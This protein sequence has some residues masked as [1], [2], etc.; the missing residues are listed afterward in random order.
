DSIMDTS[1]LETTPTSP[2]SFSH[3]EEQ[4]DWSGSQQTVVEKELSTY[5]SHLQEAPCSDI[6]RQAANAQPPSSMPIRHLGV[7]PLIRASR[8][9]LARPAW[10]SEES[11]SV[12]SDSYGSTFSLYRG[13]T[14]SIPISL[15]EDGFR[16]EPYGD[17]TPDLYQRKVRDT[18]KTE[19][20]QPTWR[21]SV[22]PPPSPAASAPSGT[23]QQGSRTTL[24]GPSGQPSTPLTP[25]K[26]ILT[27]AEY[28]DN[29]PEE[30][31]EKV[32]KPKSSALSQTSTQESRPQ[33]PLS[34]TSSKV[35]VLRPSPKLV[36]SG[37]KIFDKVKYYEERRKSF[38]Q[39]D[40]PFPVHSWLPFRK[41]RSFDQPD[42]N[43]RGGRGVT[44][45]TSTEDLR[46]I[47]S[48]YGGATQRRTMFKQKASSFDERSKFASRVHD[49][50]HKFSEELSR[51]KK[52]VSKQQMARSQEL[53]RLGVKGGPGPRPVMAFK[54]EPSSTLGTH[55]ITTQKPKL[56]VAP[57]SQAVGGEQ[58]QPTAVV[59]VRKGAEDWE[60]PV[61]TVSRKPLERSSVLTNKPAEMEETEA[62]DHK[63]KV[64]APV[65]SPSPRP[66][67]LPQILV[68][69]SKEIED[70]SMEDVEKGHV[71]VGERKGKMG[72]L[73]EGKVT[74]SKGKSK[75][76][77]PTSPETAESSDDSY[78]SAGEDPLEPPVFEIPIQDTV[79]TA[80]SEVLL[81]CI[82]TGNP[83]P[84]VCWK[85]DN[86]ILKSCPTHLIKAEGERHTLLI[87]R[88]SLSDAGVYCISA[89]NEEGMSSSSATLKVK[90]GE[91]GST[92]LRFSFPITSD[93]EYLSPLE[94][95]VEFG[96]ASY[97][98]VPTMKIQDAMDRNACEPRSPI[99]AHFKA[100]PT[101]EVS[102]CDQ[103]V[104]E[105][106]DVTLSVRVQGEPKPM[107]Y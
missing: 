79:V 75:R 74:R 9:N 34:E 85:K 63:T 57:M 32:K 83:L 37:S 96:V 42:A 82:L 60:P 105:G 81:K 89:S 24:S 17:R 58:P 88:A 30:F 38:D 100:P 40:S 21:P 1:P 23:S 43:E 93:E 49:I 64:Q 56:A 77:R 98:T 107:I 46:E 31:E 86:I 28:Q 18:S 39:S 72:A 62:V 102:L 33:T 69:A 101:L 6:S 73:Q 3:L 80:G 87:Q 59:T 25:R 8:A 22:L 2:Q 71:K 84:E 54:C 5:P 36:R 52:T 76:L 106:Q 50:E 13:K 66:V 27:P 97:R 67:V 12:I 26:K 16:K 19:A 103:S 45:E 55:S 61:M 15:S 20:Q 53:L 10:G 41:S 95:G 29:V 68:G 91:R 48:E 90:P 51:I 47:R 14:F 94:E 104:T 7:E 92:S 70:V 35:S 44:P 4:S 99:E 11:L 65:A 78:V